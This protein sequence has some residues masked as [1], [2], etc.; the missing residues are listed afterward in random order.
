MNLHSF[1]NQTHLRTCFQNQRESK[2]VH[3]NFIEICL[4][5]VIE[6]ALDLVSRV[7]TIG[8]S[9]DEFEFTK[10]ILSTRTSLELSSFSPQCSSHQS[11][12]I[13]SFRCRRC[14]IRSCERNAL[15]RHVSMAPGEPSQL[16]TKLLKEQLGTEERGRESSTEERGHDRRERERFYREACPRE[17]R[18]K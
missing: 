7:N 18:T 8:L 3:P 10:L 4:C 12:S 5:V 1:L 15:R 17:L 11:R 13:L 16:G 6:I 14:H 2:L 9:A